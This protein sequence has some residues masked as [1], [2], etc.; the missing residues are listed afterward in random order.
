MPRTTLKPACYQSFVTGKSGAVVPASGGNLFG[1]CLRP[2][3]GME[4]LPL[5]IDA[6]AL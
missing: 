4:T 5:L 1:V 3:D 6:I 2:F